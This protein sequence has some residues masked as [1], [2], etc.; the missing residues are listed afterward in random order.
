MDKQQNIFTAIKQ[1]VRD[2]MRPMRDEMHQFKNEMLTSNDKVVKELKDLRQEVAMFN[3]GQRRQ[4]E[5]LQEHSHRLKV[6]ETKIG[7]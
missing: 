6:V 3:G 7:I 2:E 5:Q 1:V 4:D